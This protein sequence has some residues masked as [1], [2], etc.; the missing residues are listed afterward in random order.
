MHMALD[1]I[2]FDLIQPC[3]NSQKTSFAKDY[4]C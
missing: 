2:R 4:L 3:L 1:E